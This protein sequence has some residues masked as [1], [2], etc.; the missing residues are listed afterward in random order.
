MDENLVRA[1]FTGGLVLSGSGDRPRLS[2][3]I[4]S[5]RGFIYLRENEF[6]LGDSAVT[7]T[8]DSVYPKFNITASGTVTGRTVR[9]DTPVTQR[10]PITLT[11][12]GEFVTRAGG[13]VA[14][15]LDTTLACTQVG[16]DCADPTTGVPYGEAELYALVA[17]GV[18]NLATLPNNLAALGSSA[19]QTA[20]NVFVLGELERTVAQAFGLDVFRF[21]PQL[22]GDSLGA[23]I[24]LGSYLTRNLYLQ[25]QVDLTGQGLLNAE[26]STPDGRLTFKVTTPLRGLNLQSIRPSFSAGYNVNPRT[27]ISLGV[28][29]TEQS[30][31]LRFGVTYRIGG[32]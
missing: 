30:T 18:P 1:E 15:D 28:Q 29:T 21:T 11:L 3:E 26:Y 24:T 22:L 4:R 27:N 8:G 2:G 12:A 5:Q 23:T 16:G 32:R 13:E 25:Y 6:T 20:L 7:F 14:L 9:G 19:L 17:T 10:V 31:R